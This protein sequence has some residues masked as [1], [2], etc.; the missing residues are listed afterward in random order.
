M[1]FPDTPLPITVELDLGGT[2]TDISDD[3]YERDTIRITRGRSDWG[4]QVDHGRCVFTLN[5][6]TGNYSLR[7]PL[8]DY[9]ELIGRNTP[10]RVSVGAGDAYLA[11]TGSSTGYASTPDTA[12][13]DVTGDLDIRIEA[14][15]DNWQ[16]ESGSVEFAAKYQIS[17]DNRSWYFR[18]TSGIPGLSW[19][20]DGTLASVI[21]ATATE[22]IVFPTSNRIALRATLDVDNLD[23]GHTVT[24][25]TS[26]SISGEWTRLGDPVVTS[27]TTSV[28]AGTA[29]LEVGTAADIVG[30]PAQGRIYAFQLLDGINGNTAADIDFT[31]QTVDETSFVGD[32]GLTWTVQGDAAISNRKVRFLGEIASWPVRWDTG[33]DDVYV[34]VEAAGIMRRLGQGAAPLQST[35]RR[36]IPSDPNLLAYWPLEDGE[37]ATQAASALSNVRAMISSGLDYGSVDTLAGSSALPTL[38]SQS[39]AHLPMIHGFVPYSATGEWMVEFVYKRDDPDATLYTHMRILTSGTVREWYLQM[40]STGGRVLGR[41]G[42]GN[43]VVDD[44][45]VW[46]TVT[47]FGDWYRMRFAV[48]PDGSNIDYTLSWIQVADST[49][50]WSGT[51][52][53]T[54]GRVTAVTAPPNGYAAALDGMALG[55]I[56]VFSSAT[57]TIFDYA[58]HGYSGETAGA[59]ITR[60]AAE[61]DVALRLY[62]STTR[63]EL[64]GPQTPDRL[65]DVLRAAADA[66]QGILYEERE[67]V[68]LAY[69]DRFSFYNQDDG[70][71]LDY[72]GTDGLVTP[73]D[74][75]DDD[76]HVRNDVTVTRVGGSSARVT[77]TSGPL[78]TLPPPSGVGAYP[79][80]VTRNLY[81]DSQAEQAAGWMMHLGTWDETRYPVIKVLLQNAVHLIEDAAAVDI[82]SRLA[83]TNPPSWLPPDAIDEHVQGYTEILHQFRWE[84]EWTCTPSG[85]WTVAVVDNPVN[86]RLGTAGSE[87][88]VAVDSDDT[89][90]TVATTDSPLWITSASHPSEDLFNIKL[91]GEV[92]TVTAISSAISDAFARTESNGW[93]AADVGGAWTNDGGSAANYSVGGGV[94]VHTL[95]SVNASRRST[96]PAPSADVDLYA[97]VATSALATGG[98]IGGGPVVRYSDGNNLYMARLTFNTSG[99]IELDIRSRVSSSETSIGSHTLTATHTAGT[100]YRVRFQVIGDD[101]RAKAWPVTGAEPNGWQLAVTDAALSGVGSVGVR[102]ILSSANT[103]VNPEVRYDNFELV[104]PQTFTVQRSVN[105]VTKAHTVGTAVALATPAIVAL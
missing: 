38:D 13:L 27:G 39:G 10:V 95:T 45:F 32:D 29:V 74:P 52:A 94:G 9:Y 88:A 42:D 48:T 35:L 11:L 59:R 65:L 84:L 105:T 33:G 14:A 73:L 81:R 70:L 28:H 96:L 83:I 103:N 90:L 64:M 91:G 63:Q 99:S 97:D 101:L 60:L 37:N 75:V 18:I 61:E 82:G 26:D 4:Q 23:S 5:N 89:T 66:D 40:S 12:I 93:G 71:T 72:T 69:R 104:N 100:F 47:P 49:I 98:F 92:V 15:L 58:D 2:W 20:P 50:S 31:A 24:F 8:G 41:D 85:P 19:S 17:G 62:G 36:R 54:V 46:T 51:V 77:Q 53:G 6:A 68:A 80:A 16:E 22:A 44:P 34:Q 1:T 25:Y 86:A 30:V 67:A 21:S 43:D 56:A 76:Q 79:D 55:H 3:V 87:L 78:S 57:S 102:S 7:N